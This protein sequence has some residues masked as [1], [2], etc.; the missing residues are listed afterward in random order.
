MSTT[1]NFPSP[2]EILKV[3]GDMTIEE[4]EVLYKTCQ[5]MRPLQIAEDSNMSY[6]NYSYHMR[7]VYQ[8]LELPG[9]KEKRQLLLTRICPIIRANFKTLDEIITYSPTIEELIDVTPEFA[10]IKKGEIIE[11][12]KQALPPED[13]DEK[14][15]FIPPPVDE[16]PEP[17]GRRELPGWLRVV[18]IITASI[19]GMIIVVWIG[20]RV[21]IWV[22][23]QIVDREDQVVVVPT[24]TYTQTSIPSPTKSPTIT[25]TRG[26]TPTRTPYITPTITPTPEYQLFFDDFSSGLDKW[27]IL[28]GEVYL[29]NG[30]VTGTDGVYHSWIMVGNENWTDYS[31][32]LEP[33]WTWPY[34]ELY[35]G[36][37][38]KDQNNM[39]AAQVRQD[40]M[41]WTIF[42]NGED[43][44]IRDSREDSPFKCEKIVVKVSGNEFI[45]RCGSKTI[46]TFYN[47]DPSF[48]S[49]GVVLG[50]KSGI[51]IDNVEINEVE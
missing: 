8:K 41:N 15:E 22:M 4:R 42:K 32:I 40:F 14:P 6:D 17:T 9:G 36:V 13:G 2:T 24:A 23:E 10:E 49:G 29:V 34:T 47:T 11:E 38:A 48:N 26:P 28:E 3:I 46:S 1:E 16:E 50:V 7:K 25:P 33:E 20:C 5:G 37:R 51:A 19:V 35:I 12:F 30:K 18:G 39:M 27:R 44:W 43:T 31:V 45:A 21:A